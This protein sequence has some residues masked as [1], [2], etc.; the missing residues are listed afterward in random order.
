MLLPQGRLL[1]READSQREL[2]G[3]AQAGVAQAA[4]GKEA[5]S[6]SVP[7]LLGALSPPSFSII[8][9]KKIST[10]PLHL[11]AFKLLPLFTQ[12]HQPREPEPPPLSFCLHKELELF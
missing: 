4:G 3:G 10:C 5:G 2:G 1:L 9:K 8:G 11:L 6:I 12:G 7:W